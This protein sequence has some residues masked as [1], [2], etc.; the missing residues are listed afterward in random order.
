MDAD[1]AYYIPGWLRT[2][3]G[4]DD[5]R[6][7]FV[8][9]FPDARHVFWD[10]WPGNGMWMTAL[11]NAE[12]SWTRLALEI[13]SMTDDERAN[14]VLVGHSLGARIVIRT[15]AFLA[16]YGKKVKS[17]ALLGAAIPN[18]DPDLIAIGRGSVLPILAVCNPLDVT[19]KYMYSIAGGEGGVA[20]GTDGAARTGK[21]QGD[22]GPWVGCLRN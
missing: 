3:G 14:V 11:R 15:L 4:N 16:R 13:I 7:S 9:T 1:V 18:D 2:G 6:A 17:A 19:L 12:L 21:C 20:F 8:A 10:A 22:F 5:T